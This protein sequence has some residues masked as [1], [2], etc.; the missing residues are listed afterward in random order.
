MANVVSINLEKDIEKKVKEYAEERGVSKSQAV[1][2]LLNM[3]LGSDNKANSLVIPEH[4]LEE[5]LYSVLT[6]RKTL[7][8]WIL[9]EEITVEG[10]E[11]IR[12]Q[13][14]EQA[15]DL[16]LSGVS[17]P[18]IDAKKKASMRRR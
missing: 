4:V 11:N 7:L 5:I 17:L 13:S 14:R 2:E 1:N 9:N 10:W 12:Q 16:I 15:R 6:L 18:D 3:G 8:A